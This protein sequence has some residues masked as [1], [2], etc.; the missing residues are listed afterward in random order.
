MR[1][2]LSRGGLKQLAVKGQECRQPTSM[3]ARDGKNIPYLTMPRLCFHV[4]EMGEAATSVAFERAWQ[5]ECGRYRLG[6]SVSCPAVASALGSRCY[7]N[8]GRTIDSRHLTRGSTISRQFLYSNAGMR[9][10]NERCEPLRLLCMSRLR[11]AERPGLGVSTEWVDNTRTNPRM[12]RVDRSW[13]KSGGRPSPMA[14][15][16]VG[17]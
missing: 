11:K 9:S 4:A 1:V 10:R 16:F 13:T 2:V 8:E 17:G 6:R 15:G 12:G 7:R 3:L 5:Q 14:G